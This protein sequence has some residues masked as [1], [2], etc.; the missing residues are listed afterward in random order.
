MV[1]DQEFSYKRFNI[2]IRNNLLACVQVHVWG[3]NV[4]GHNGQ[5]A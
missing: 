4:S 1:Y 5:S 2:N 3:A